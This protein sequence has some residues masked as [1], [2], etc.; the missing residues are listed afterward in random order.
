MTEDEITAAQQ[1]CDTNM[2]AA[3]FLGQHKLKKANVALAEFDLASSPRTTPSKLRWA[4]PV[5]ADTCDVAMP[6]EWKWGSRGDPTFVDNKVVMAFLTRRME[7]NE[8]PSTWRAVAMQFDKERGNGMALDLLQPP[9]V[10]EALAD[11]SPEP[12][13]A[14]AQ[15]SGAQPPK[16]PEPPK[17]PALADES[18]EPS[19]ALQLDRRLPS[20]LESPG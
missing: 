20:Q 5:V 14:A 15:S 6:D 16:A 17:A 18:M 12:S 4:E 9:K 7:S 1:Q 3:Q 11:E 10:P 2:K 8:L 13:A 19:A